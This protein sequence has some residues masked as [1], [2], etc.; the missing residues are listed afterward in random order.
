M[1]AAVVHLEADQ[2]LS[3]APPG[4]SELLALARSRSI[5]D[6]QRL[7]LGVAALAQSA[8]IGAEAAALMGEV[9]MALA[10]QAERD[11]RRILA[12][13][14]A[15]ADWAPPALINIL[16]L[17]EIEIARPIIA[18]S[19]L[20]K[21]ADL[22]RI[23]VE[24]TIDHQI[25]VAR[26]PHISGRVVD[27]VIER[28]DAAV[29]TALAGNRTAEISEAGLRRLVDESRRIAALRAPLTRHPRLT[30][31]MASQLYHWV[32]QA[33]RQAIA[34]RFRVDE[35]ALDTAVR[36]AADRAAAGRFADTDTDPEPS[37]ADREEM[38]RRLIAKL[39]GAG[40]LRAGFLIRA[41][42]EARLG[43][44]EQ[45]LAA[46][47]GFS[48]QQ[49]RQA[50]GASSPEPLFYACVAVGIDRAV[51]PPLL[52]AIR[53]LNDGHPVGTASS[54]TNLG[55]SPGAASRAFRA[56]MTDPIR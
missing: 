3:G 2:A 19:P 7:L 38:D 41:V 40:Q 52:N 30:D 26:R 42:R 51:F 17:D 9:F 31:A 25:E 45:G 35:T 27:K 55:L 36:S 14:L 6:R 16:A 10:G 32:G 49:V 56:W 34:E 24:A 8:P 48:L 28:G 4:P 54:Q 15:T 5:E 18:S 1:T 21:D 29:L 46:L 44:F 22:I 20:L 33:L 13:T 43:L 12:E 11:I 53:R 47:G 39:H 37:P 50:L 23:L